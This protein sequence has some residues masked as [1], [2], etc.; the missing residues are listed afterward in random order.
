MPHQFEQN[1]WNSDPEQR[2]SFKRL[3]S[4]SPTQNVSFLDFLLA[5]LKC[6]RMCPPPQ[7]EW[8]SPA[9]IDLQISLS[10]R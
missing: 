6:R 7:R 5:W 9:S 3:P 1:L 10:T 8:T 4:D 2:E